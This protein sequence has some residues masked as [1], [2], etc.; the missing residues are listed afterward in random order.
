MGASW[1]EGPMV[2]SHRLVVALLGVV[3]LI[4]V[5]RSGGV[6]VRANGEATRMLRTP[7]VSATHVAFAYANNIW[8]VE[9]NGGTSRRLTSAQGQAG[10]PKFSPDG[11][12]I[13]FTAD[14]GG[15]PDVYVV[16]AEGGE[17]CLL[18]TSPSPRDTERSRMPS[19]A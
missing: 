19:S 2:F 6:E 8:V 16:P 9:R 18:Y 13:A 1:E 3:S 10:N 14:Y 5:A 11:R 15:N 12:T 7:T 17:P 4:V